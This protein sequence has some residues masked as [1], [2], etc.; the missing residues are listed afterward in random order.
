MPSASSKSSV[1]SLRVGSNGTSRTRRRSRKSVEV[2]S[3]RSCAASTS[4]ASTGSPA[5]RV[6]PSSSITRAE[7]A[8]A[9]AEMSCTSSFPGVG[10]SPAS[11]RRFSVSVPVLSDAT[12]VALPSAST[13]T[14]LRT[15]A[16]RSAI[17]RAPSAS[18]I[19]TVATSPSGTAATATETPTR[20]ASCSD[21]PSA[22]MAPLSA[23]VTTT[24]TRTITRVRPPTRR[25]R[26]VGGGFARS[27]SP[28][29][30][31][32]SVAEPVAVTSSVPR[33]RVTAVPA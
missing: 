23:S 19:V 17:A 33:P 21:S 4:A 18:A 11:R 20:N 2:D 8:S 12:T 6:L 30:L 13:A 16:P 31:P 32:S 27:V 26:G 15:M 22:S 1:I 9:A 25:C 5:T 28:A 24:P 3:P 10:A 29:I 7:D 14:S